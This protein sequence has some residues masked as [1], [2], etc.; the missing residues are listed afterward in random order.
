MSDSL[1]FP[2]ALWSVRNKDL[3]NT[4]PM[5]VSFFEMLEYSHASV[6]S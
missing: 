5:L 2:V 1:D 3:G 6:K 4:M